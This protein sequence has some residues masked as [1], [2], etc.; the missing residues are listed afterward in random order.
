ML[1][2]LHTVF[3]NFVGFYIFRKRRQVT[4]LRVG[5]VTEQSSS[6]MLD[7]HELQHLF[8]AF[9]PETINF[10]ENSN[11]YNHLQF[12]INEQK[13]WKNCQTEVHK[14]ARSMVMFVQRSTSTWKKQCHAQL[15]VFDTM[16]LLGTESRDNNFNYAY[17]DA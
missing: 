1:I 9:L 3:A 8:S 6:W 15:F 17:C 12:C 14:V 5:V 4:T 2:R 7:G 11:Q 16:Q 13:T 10:Q